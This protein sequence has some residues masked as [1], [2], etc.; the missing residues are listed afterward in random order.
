MSHDII[1]YLYVYPSNEASL[2]RS[3]ILH[4]LNDWRLHD[5]LQNIRSNVIVNSCFWGTYKY[6]C[7]LVMFAFCLPVSW[8]LH[9]HVQRKLPN[10]I[11]R[12]NHCQLSYIIHTSYF[13]CITISH[14]HWSFWTSTTSPS[15]Y[16]LPLFPRAFNF[17]VSC[18]IRLQLN[19]PR[20]F[21][22]LYLGRYLL[23]FT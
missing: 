19:G 3:L 6:F 1:L 15:R 14:N 23:D 10:F 12:I 22:K 5:Y 7:R 17:V 8:V 11:M 13:L 21:L 16:H 18:Q 2:T 20:P 4:A 9:L